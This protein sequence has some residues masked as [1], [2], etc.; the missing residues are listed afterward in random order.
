M[1]KWPFPRLCWSFLYASRNYQNGLCYYWLRNYV[2]AWPHQKPVYTELSPL[3]LL[4]TFTSHT[5]W[6]IPGS[7]LLLRTAS[8]GKLG[9]GAGNKAMK[10]PWNLISL[11]YH[12]GDLLASYAHVWKCDRRQMASRIWLSIITQWNRQ[13]MYFRDIICRWHNLKLNW[14]VEVVWTWPTQRTSASSLDHWSRVK[15]KR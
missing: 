12:G 8:D 15:C 2:H 13:R 14:V 3:Y 5:W 9:G 11:Y 4:S 6:I 1:P 10:I 7:L